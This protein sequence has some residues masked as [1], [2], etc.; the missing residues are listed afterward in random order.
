MPTLLET[1]L[2][3]S[4]LFDVEA[5][6][7][8]YPW[9]V[10]S[11]HDCILSPDADGQLCGL[12]LSNALGW[13]IRGF[14]DGKALVVDAGVDPSR[15]IYVDMEICRAG[16]RSFGNHMLA[17]NLGRRSDDWDVRF[18]DCFSINNWRSHD[19]RAFNRK[20]PFA[21]IHFLLPTLAARFPITVPPTAAG[22]LLFADGVYKILL[23]YTENA[24]D[25]MRYLGVERSESPLHSLFHSPD[26]SVYEV[27]TKMLDFWRRRDE[28]ST[29]GH[30]G[31]RIAITERGGDGRVVNL[32]E[33]GSG[34]ARTWRYADEPRGRI[35][36]FLTMLGE[37]T[38]W[39]YRKSMWTWS[40][41]RLVEFEKRIASDVTDLAA[42]RGIMDRSPLSWAITARDRVEYTL[43]PHGVF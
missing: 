35:E 43:D 37:L 11:G 12:L 40:G 30:R 6:I 22:P 32:I 25:W 24:W 14:Y 33:S 23:Q 20:Y 3:A 5:V 39:P 41:W 34:S 10:G 28:L 18:A 38:G 26:L 31:D 4:D 9:V 27:M 16:V 8:R 19:R 42:F 7:A 13:R 21:S 15:C 36:T 29:T 2:A 1:V 17:F